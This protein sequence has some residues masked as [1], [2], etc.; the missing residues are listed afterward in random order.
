MKDPLTTE[1][2]LNMLLK[3]E[4]ENEILLQSIA[5]QQHIIKNLENKL[6]VIKSCCL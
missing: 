2:L 1:E 6:E 3:M 4:K 5:K